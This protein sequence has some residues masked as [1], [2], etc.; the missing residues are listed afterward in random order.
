MSEPQRVIMNEEMA[1]VQSSLD[2]ALDHFGKTALR[3]KDE[4]DQ[5]IHVIDTVIANLAFYLKRFPISEG[6]QEGGELASAVA[7]LLDYTR[8]QRSRLA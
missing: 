3:I 8:D 6:N 4:R 2:A 7:Q 5:A 1:E